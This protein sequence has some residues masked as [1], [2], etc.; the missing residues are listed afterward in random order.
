VEIGIGLA[1]AVALLTNLASLLKH[2]GC[3]RARPVRISRPLASIQGLAGSP[4]F[5][6]GWGLAAVAWL[7]HV[8]ALSLAPISLVQAVL[9]GG[10]VTI[11]VIAQRLFG[12]SVERR[13]WLALILGAAGLALLAATL[14]HLRG[15]HSDFSLAAISSFE[16]G[17]VLVAAGIALGHRAGRIAARRGVS[18]A[19]L[20]GLLFALSGIAIKGL[21]GG[22]SG[23]WPLI[24]SLVVLTVGCGALAQFSTVA[25]LQSGGA[26]ETIGLMGLVANA[27][28]IVGGVLVFG[29]PVSPSPFGIALQATAFGM[30]CVS[31]LLMPSSAASQVASPEAPLPA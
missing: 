18:L 14:P 31:A 16:G 3:Q 23:S 27:A 17:L 4:W 15:T 2:R 22:A 10:A 11:A 7:V 24:A 13:Q 21:T 20:A 8:A 28:Q 6:A 19:V 30:V 29:D 9:A 12:D 5:V 1:V 25:A 26:I